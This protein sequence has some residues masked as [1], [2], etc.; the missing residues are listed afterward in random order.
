MKSVCRHSTWEDCYEAQWS[1][2]ITP[3]A[4]AHPAKF[5]RGLIERI[6]DYC[7]AEGY[8]RAGDVVGDPFGGVGTGG[9]IAAYRRLRWFGLELEPRFVALGNENLALHKGRWPAATLGDAMLLQGDSRRFHEAW[10]AAPRFSGM[11]TS[12]PYADSISAQESGIDWS[13]GTGGRDFTKEQRHQGLRKPMGLEYGSGSG[14]IGALKS[15][16]LDAAV[17][18]PP[19]A[20]IAA[21]AGGLNSRPARKPGQQCGRTG[22]GSQAADQK[23]GRAEG[24]IS[25]LASGTIDGAVTSPPWVDCNL[26][27]DKNFMEKRAA[28]NRN[29]SRFQPDIGSYGT[30]P[31]Q[32]GALKAASAN[33]KAAAAET[34][35]MAMKQVYASCHLAIKPGGVLVVVVKDYVAKKQRV[36][37]CD[38]TCR[39]L[40]HGGF[41]IEE[42]IRAMLVS[43][44]VH[45]DLF[46]GET[47]VKRSRKS[48]FRHLAEQNGSPPIDY[49]EVII[50]R[51]AE[52]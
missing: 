47:V 36:P 37:L 7:L 8:L 51:R 31:D 34:Y 21:G 39:L 25:Q 45:P 2:M 35:W 19:Y 33:G 10:H 30:S 12:P 17:T 24:Q 44:T 23:Y 4:F 9:I 5:S 20:D 18:S 49:E 16:N 38:D 13:K 41:T 14:Q 22:G 26:S 28:E 32:I 3:A 43:R 6:Y 52:A 40:E 1:G 42:R 46:Q 27:I 15:G 48:F 11:V 50:A 29:G